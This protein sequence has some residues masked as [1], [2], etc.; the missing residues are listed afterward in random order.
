MLGTRCGRCGGDDEEDGAVAAD[1][2]EEAE[3]DVIGP[4]GCHGAVVFLPES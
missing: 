4:P 2:D 1:E 3:D